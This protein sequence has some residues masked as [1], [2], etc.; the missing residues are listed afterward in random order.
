MKYVESLRSA[1][2]LLLETDDNVFILGEDIID[3]YGGAFKVTKGLSE[4]F[5]DRVIATPISEAAITGAGIGM[6]M[7]GIHPIV[8]IMFGDF[9]ALA[10]DQIVNSASKFN[11]MYNNRVTVPLVV[12]L[13]MGGYRGYGPTHSQSLE[14]MFMGI[15]SIRIVS[16]SL[17][18]NPGT[19]LKSS[20]KR[21]ETTLFIEHK[22]L[23]SLPLFPDSE[24]RQSIAPDHCLIIED[25]D[26]PTVSLSFARDAR[27]DVT[28]IAYGHMVS[29]AVEASRDLILDHEIIVEIIAPSLIKPVPLSDFSA[30]I[31]RSR[32]VVIV[33]EGCKTGGWG[34][35]ISALIHEQL[36]DFVN[37][38]VSRIGA[39]DIPVPSSKA[40]EEEVLPS[41]AGI[42]TEILRL[43]A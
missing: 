17:Y 8:E 37:C 31:E 6:A 2:R 30:A 12:R 27:P 21:S 10:A 7:R 9:V 5:P 40:A 28:V 23:Y 32:R 22:A 3:P 43:L 39:K 19:L 24:S 34:A 20:V 35:E 36:G 42:K 38:A 18:H 11:W 14:M 25:S 16:P 1:L 4:D 13:P 15:P 26:F 29:L 33:E 41:V